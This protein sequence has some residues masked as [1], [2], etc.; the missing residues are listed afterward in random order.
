MSSVSKNPDFVRLIERL[1]RFR[2]DRD[3]QQF[4]RLKDLILSLNLEAAEM[5][6]LCQWKSD[7]EVEQAVSDPAFREKLEHEL[8]DVLVY[9]LLIAERTGIDLIAATDAKIDHNAAKYPAD[10]ARGRADKY[11]AYEEE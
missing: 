8:A 2:D 10:K 1:L 6:E 3:W 11:T 5:L 9:L 4:H 7:A